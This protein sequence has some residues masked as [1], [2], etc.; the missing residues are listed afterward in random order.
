MTFISERA[1][2]VLHERYGGINYDYFV[3]TFAVEL[4]GSLDDPDLTAT[5]AAYYKLLIALDIRERSQ[6]RVPDFEPL[7][8]ETITEAAQTIA[9]GV[10]I[11][12]HLF[13]G[14]EDSYRIACANIKQ[15]PHDDIVF[16]RDLANGKVLFDF[17]IGQQTS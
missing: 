8:E 15:R 1:L 2:A 12:E 10:E 7:L 11:P 14:A 4:L 6:K 5:T 13:A 17:Q 9:H 3:D 16:L